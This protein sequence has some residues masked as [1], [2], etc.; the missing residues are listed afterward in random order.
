MEMTMPA[1]SR[2][3]MAALIPI[4][5]VDHRPRLSFADAE[6]DCL[7]IFHDT[8]M[9]RGPF[10]HLC[11]PGEGQQVIFS[12]RD[13]FEYGML[14]MAMCAFDCSETRIIT[15]E[16]MANHIH[17]VLCGR[18]DDCE[19]WFELF[20]KRLR[21]YLA[22]SNSGVSL[23]HFRHGLIPVESIESLRA[24]IAYVNRNMFLVDSMQTPW[25]WPYGAN[26]FYF[27]ELQKQQYSCKFGDLSL[28]KRRALMHVHECDYPDDAL[29]IGN[30]FSPMSF[31][32]IALGESIFRDARHY[33]HKVS[34]DVE[35][36]REVASTID[37]RVCC[38][39]EEL[40]SAAYLICERKYNGQKPNLLP[41]DKKLEMAGTMHYDY[42]AGNKAISKILNLDIHILEEMY[43][44]RR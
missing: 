3:E 36:Y 26:G 27:M 2:S 15:F 29:M 20:R 33:F 6:N 42:R 4:A 39:Y 23:K 12:S 13:D 17:A 28:R 41:P 44:S 31:C 32:D 43:P 9:S 38:T 21:L 25:S 24:H 35:G 18:K 11:T 19:A 1:A 8:L 22:R 7:R 37:D 34:R 14:L 30:Y 16:L 5:S 10:W 40:S